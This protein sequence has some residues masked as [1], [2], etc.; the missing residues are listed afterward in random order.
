MAYRFRCEGLARLFVRSLF[1]E[2][3]H[4]ALQMPCGY[5]VDTQM[6]YRRINTVG[7]LE[8]SLVCSASEGVLSVVLEP[9][10]RKFLKLHSGSLETVVDRFLKHDRLT[11]QFLFDL[12]L[13][14]TLVGLPGHGLFLVIAVYIVA[15]AHSDKI[16]VAT[17]LYRCHR[18]PP[19][20]YDIPLYIYDCSA[21]FRACQEI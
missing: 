20:I 4:E 12:L 21:I 17:F 19:K 8:H 2:R 1:G 3:V 5:L 18:L 7:E 16:A 10:L 9:F 11:V 14:H 13:G 15:A 6:P